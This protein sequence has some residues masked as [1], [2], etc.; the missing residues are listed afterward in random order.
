M[1]EIH[2][3]SRVTVRKRKKSS[4]THKDS[5][6]ARESKESDIPIEEWFPEIDVSCSPVQLTVYKLLF[7]HGGM[8][9]DNP[10]SYVNGDTKVI[11]WYDPEKLCVWT[12]LSL[13]ASLGYEAN[14][15]K[16]L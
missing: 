15:I 9:V 5:K 8:L 4:E 6:A 1:R 2:E 16:Q 7:H 14:T 11:E 13:A 10:R 12:L 3:D